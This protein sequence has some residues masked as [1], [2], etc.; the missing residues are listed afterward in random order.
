MLSKKFL[1]CTIIIVIIAL[2]SSCIY[3]SPE[4]KTVLN[5]TV[6]SGI[7]PTYSWGDTRVDYLRVNYYDSYGKIV[8]GIQSDESNN[9]SSPVRHGI[10]PENAHI[11]NFGI[12]VPIDTTIFGKPLVPGKSYI[13]T[14]GRMD[15]F[16]GGEKQFFC[17]ADSLN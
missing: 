17:T 5:I 7:N 9:I 3:C 16:T 2:F 13:I 1:L 8:M 15:E 11:Y 10:I 6:S 14:I 4:E 12:E